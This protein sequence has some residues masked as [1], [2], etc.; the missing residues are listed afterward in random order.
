MFHFQIALTGETIFFHFVP[1]LLPIF[2]RGP[3]QKLNEVHRGAVLYLFPCVSVTAN[4]WTLTSKTRQ[5]G[6]LSHVLSTSNYSW[7]VC[8][9]K[10]VFPK[11]TLDVSVPLSSQNTLHKT[12]LLFFIT[13]FRC[14][15]KTMNTILS[16]ICCQNNEY[17]AKSKNQLIDLH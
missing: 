9:Q 14:I 8:L 7:T 15:V 17:N 12:M 16:M 3:T 13:N 5:L 4:F 6:Q 2:R 10:P 1:S 11:R